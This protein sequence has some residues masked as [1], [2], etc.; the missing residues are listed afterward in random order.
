MPLSPGERVV[1]A[2]LVGRVLATSLLLLWSHAVA[3]AEPLIVPPSIT[4]FVEAVLPE[5][6]VD[7]APEGAERVEVVITM[8][9]GANG[10]VT[11]ASV[12]SG[13]GDPFDAAA[14][15]A[16]K[17]FVFEPATADG[18]PVPVTVP[19]TYVF[20]ISRPAPGPP[21][22]E[23][24]EPPEIVRPVGEG[25]VFGGVAERGSRAPLAGVLVTLEA[26]DGRD[27]PMMDTVSDA[28]GSFRFE[29]VPDGK[30]LLRG[31][32]EDESEARGVATVKDGATI[33]VGWLYGRRG[34]LSLYRTVV[35]D[36]GRQ[37]SATK[38]S[39]SEAELKTVPGTLGEPTRVVATLPGVARSPFGLPY[40]VVRGAGFENTGTLIDGF[41][42]YILYH[43]FGGP[44]VISSEFIGGLD[45]Y[46][47]GFP[48]EFG[49]YTAGLIDVETKD[50]PRDTWHVAAEL[51]LLKASVVVSVPFADGKGVFA[52][53]I[54]G[55]WA[56]LI[57]SAIE[58]TAEFYYWDY[59]LRMTYDFSLDTR[60]TVFAFGS[61]DHLIISSEEENEGLNQEGS[62]TLSETLF[63]RV[64]VRLTHQ[65]SNRLRL[66]SDT[67]LG[68]IGLETSSSSPGQPEFLFDVDILLA[69]QRLA[70][71]YDSGGVSLAAGVDFESQYVVADLAVPAPAGFAEYPAPTEDA[72][73]FNGKL[74]V[75]EVDTAFWADMSVRLLPQLTLVPGLRAEIFHWNGA[76]HLAVD[77][78]LTVRAAVTDW[79][80]F[81]GNVG[82]YHQAP[83]FEEVDERFGNPNLEPLSSLQTSFGAELT[84]GEDDE[85]QVSATG[86]YNYMY[87]LPIASADFAVDGDAN[88]DRENYTNDGRGRSYGLE[89]MFRK[90]VGEYMFGWV[91][92]TLSRSERSFASGFSEKNLDS[93]TWQAFAFDQTHILNIAWTF[94]LPLDM[95]LGARFRLSSGNPGRRV[96]GS[97]YNADTDGYEPK[98]GPIE[99]LPV[100]H[101]LDIRFD[102]KFIFDTFFIEAYLD[103]QNVY[104]AR[105]AEFYVYNF[106]YSKRKV[107]GGVPILPTIGAKVVF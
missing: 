1:R 96:T 105:N 66:R 44:A 12:R 54:R 10:S 42:A 18:Q 92:Y 78:R 69:S 52:G 19:Y 45:F 32:S 87:D 46:P 3:A 102:K 98:Y 37:K 82:I 21:A 95:S 24:Q 56:G 39:L 11:E 53:A 58:P 61:G 77:P 43:F 99:R 48:A 49:R 100:F 89:F 103:I 86:F 101:Q 28:K 65:L 2:S 50:T 72:S 80:T 94:L 55:S 93:G 23:A 73:Q 34:R 14:L 8:T 36:K 40:Y 104:Y 29:Q 20:E 60:L 7:L 33:D 70:L 5:G 31:A 57:I 59:Q 15:A 9:I 68:W 84:F 27:F 35:R 22:P 62:R 81:K 88:V 67:L 16:C 26:R 107:L 83:G 76:T 74:G 13:P 90:R 79:L 38:V 106:D 63:N 25:V 4:G 47:G 91:S 97:V 30:Y 85:W 71:F 75:Y 17:Q 64:S 6:A 51:D 41:D